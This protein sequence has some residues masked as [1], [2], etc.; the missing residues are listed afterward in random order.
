MTSEK[1]KPHAYSAGSGHLFL[2]STVYHHMSI[3][4]HDVKLWQNWNNCRF[5]RSEAT[6]KN[7]DVF[8]PT[9]PG[10]D[11]GEDVQRLIKDWF[12]AINKD[13]PNLQMSNIS[14]KQFLNIAMTIE[15]ALLKMFSKERDRSNILRRLKPFPIFW[16]L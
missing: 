16:K 7:S 1:E 5:D 2:L 6:R 13:E 11:E 12:Y 15:D 3:A 9:L 14:R 10:S 8:L 4:E